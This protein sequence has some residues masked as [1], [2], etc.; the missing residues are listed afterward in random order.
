MLDLPEELFVH[1]LDYL[2]LSSIFKLGATNRSFYQRIHQ[3]E[4][5]WRRRVKIELRL[6]LDQEDNDNGQRRDN[7][8][9]INDPSLWGAKELYLLFS[10]E[11]QKFCQ[12]KRSNIQVPSLGFAQNIINYFWNTWSSATKVS[13]PLN[14]I[15]SL[16]S[17]P[18]GFFSRNINTKGVTRQR[19]SRYESK[20]IQCCAQC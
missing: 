7:I 6:S 20:Q 16:S 15:K 17:R 4:I 1:I 13:K 11:F 3:N 9:I 5:F 18:T 14:D 8:A 19:K 12:K 2:P 10:R